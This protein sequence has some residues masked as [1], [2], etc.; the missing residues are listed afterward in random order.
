MIK[1]PQYDEETL[2]KIVSL[3]IDFKKSS[4]IKKV[5]NIPSFA[6]NKHELMPKPPRIHVNPTHFRPSVNLT[7]ILGLTFIK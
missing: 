6:N 3:F 5:E 7:P 1:T 4:M 2:N